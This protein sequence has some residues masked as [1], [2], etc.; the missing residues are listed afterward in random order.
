MHTSLTDLVA[1]TR[2]MSMTLCSSIR[3]FGI[4]HGFRLSFWWGV[5][6]VTA[7]RQAADLDAYWKVREIAER[8]R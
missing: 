1:F 5:A 3:S 6:S 2:G 7:R 8:T 4:F